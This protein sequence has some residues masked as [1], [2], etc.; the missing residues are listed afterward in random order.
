MFVRFAIV[1]VDAIVSWGECE[2]VVNNFNNNCDDDNNNVHNNDNNNANNVSNNINNDMII[3]CLCL[4]VSHI[5]HAMFGKGGYF[6]QS[7]GV[8]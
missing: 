3:F 5:P 6:F 2:T 4:I 7:Y 1:A 8:L